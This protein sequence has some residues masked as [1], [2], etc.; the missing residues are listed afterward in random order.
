MTSSYLLLGG[1]SLSKESGKCRSFPSDIMIG[2]VVEED[3]HPV[4]RH[5][6]VLGHQ[7]EHRGGVDLV[8]LAPDL[9]DAG[10][11]GGGAG[12]V[13]TAEHHG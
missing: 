12:S 8:L 13:R 1:D 10:E 2:C 3:V 5:S 7:G 6:E 9:A 4:L 11:E